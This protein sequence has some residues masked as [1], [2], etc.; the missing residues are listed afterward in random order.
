MAGNR[1]WPWVEPIA[2][3][4]AEGKARGWV[5]QAEIQAALSKPTAPEGLVGEFTVALKAKGI[6]VLDQAPGADAVPDGVTE[7]MQRLIARGKARGYVTMDELNAA[8]P[9]DQVSSEET[10]DQLA[11]LSDLGIDAVDAAEGED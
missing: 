6:R 9:R 7:A 8:L 2:A 10:E 5:T 4:T 11:M 3:L 1:F